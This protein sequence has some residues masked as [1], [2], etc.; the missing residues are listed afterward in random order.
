MFF[1]LCRWIFKFSGVWRRVNKRTFTHVLEKLAATI[2]R[3]HAVQKDL[4]YLKV[5]ISLHFILSRWFQLFTKI[6]TD[7][8]VLGSWWRRMEVGNIG[9]VSLIL[10]GRFTHSMPCPCRSPA[11]PCINSHTPWCA[12]AL[13]RQCRVFREC[14]HGSRKYLNF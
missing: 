4:S 9:D 8:Y 10:K 12:H 6:R 13:L 3:I 2:F 11:I 14:P 7:I 1:L 5:L